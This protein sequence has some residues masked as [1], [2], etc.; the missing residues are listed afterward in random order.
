MGSALIAVTA[1]GEI[2]ANEEALVVA[3]VRDELVGPQQVEERDEERDLQDQREAR[4]E[5]VDLLALVEG[6]DLL[7]HALAVALVTLLD[8]LDLRLQQLEPLHGLH[9]LERQRQ[10]HDPDREGQ[11]DDRHSPGPL[12]VPDQVVPELEDR[13]ASVDQRL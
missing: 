7:V 3:D 5:R 2:L 1:L 9:A 11:E 4:P 10:D 8:P 12:E 6:H 13:V